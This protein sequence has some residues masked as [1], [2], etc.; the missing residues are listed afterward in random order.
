MTQQ[1]LGMAY[2]LI[3]GI[4]FTVVVIVVVIQGFSTYRAKMSLTREEAYRKLAEQS[5]AALQKAADEQQKT[6][7]TLENL[8]TRLAAIEKILREVE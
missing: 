4:L 3:S 6:N 2:S 1:M 8:S 7:A 5:T